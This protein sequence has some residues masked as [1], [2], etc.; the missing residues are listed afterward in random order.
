VPDSV[1]SDP[2]T[3]PLVGSHATYDVG[4]GQELEDPGQV[5]WG[6]LEA[7]D[8]VNIFFR[9]EPYRTKFCLRA[10]GTAAEP[11]VVNGV[12]DAWGNRPRF[13]LDGARTA[14]GCNPGGGDDVFD[15]S[16][17]W[18]LE[19]Y[20]GIVIRPGVADEW[21]FRPGFLEIRNLELHG[22]R[23]GAP[24]TDI[25][26]RASAYNESPAAIWMQPSTDVLLQNNV[27]HDS[28][29]GVFTMAKDGVLSGACER[30]TLRGNRIFGNGVVGS[31]LEHNVY[32]QAANPVVE[33]NFLGVLR[34]GA[35]GATYKS[36]SSGEVFRYNYVESSLR[37]IDWVYSEEQEDGIAAQD[38][39]GV[40]F[41]YGNII[42]ND[43]DLGQCAAFPIHYGGDN[44]GEQA[45][46]AW[47]FHPGEAYRSHLYFFHNTFVS[48]VDEEEMWRVAV[49][50]LSER[51]T[52]VDAW[53][54]VFYLG[55]NAHHAWLETAGD[56]H[57]QGRNLVHGDPEDATDHALAVNYTVTVEGEL[58]DAD[59][60]FAAVHDHDFT[61]RS[62]SPACGEAAGLPD[63]LDP[64]ESYVDLPIRR[65]PRMGSNGIGERG[66]DD[67]GAVE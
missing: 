34:D 67:L 28:A 27:I 47:L 39:Y 42:V 48:L 52:R 16:S 58:I 25:E 22:A 30:V 11:V 6:A 19:D 32:M 18:S 53:D 13:D 10:R 66:A 9:E 33:G 36:R 63:G 15:T 65:Q 8:V 4:P 54:N 61:P 35:D 57:L 24:F 5:P 3:A 26:G 56:L 60:E 51:G 21:N 14:A 37:A 38:D 49:F 46:S 62:D 31:Y 1:E 40:D 7:G 59:P 23:P 2:V 45:D 44:L 29:F 64:D 12:T 20:G 17:V 55:G 41:A 43:C 50:D